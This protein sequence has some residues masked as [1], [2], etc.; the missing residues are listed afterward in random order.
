[1]VN[2]PEESSVW[3]VSLCHWV[4]SI[5]SKECILFIFWVGSSGP[6]DWEGEGIMILGKHQEPLAQ[7][8]S[9]KSQKT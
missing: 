7:Q 3:N 2:I 9:G 6:L 8:H 5:F 1:V 4:F